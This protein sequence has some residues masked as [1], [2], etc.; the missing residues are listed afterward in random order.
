[1]TQLPTLRGRGVTPNPSNRFER[2]TLEPDPATLAED[3]APA[4]PVL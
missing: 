1:M 2:L 3:P 4:N